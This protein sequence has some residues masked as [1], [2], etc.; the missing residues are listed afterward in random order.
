M[1]MRH[2]TVVAAAVGAMAAF[3]AGTGFANAQE[4]GDAIDDLTSAIDIAWLLIAGILVLFMQAGFGL[5]ESGFI[6]SK[7]VTNILMKNAL[8]LSFGAIAYWA[9]GWGLAYGTTEFIDIKFF[10]GGSFF[11]GGEDADYAG[12]FFQFAFAATAAT[13]VSGAVAE[14]TKFAA[15][16]VY[17]VVITAVIYPV[18]THWAWGDGFLSAY[19]SDIQ[20]GDNGMIDFAGSTVVHSVGGWAALVGAI[21]VGAR[22][23]KYNAGG[24]V[25]PLPGHSMPLGFLGVMIL[26]I[27]WYGFNA[28]STLG[29]SGGFADL[30]AR[31]AVTTTLAAGAGA[32][33]AMV[34]SR[35]RTGRSDLSLT[36]NGVL[37]GLVGITAG[38]AT[39][40]PW[41][42]VVIGIVAGAVIVFG[43]ELLDN[44]KID[45]PVGAVPVHLFN[46]IWGTLAVG[47]FTTQANL[48]PNYGDSSSYGLLVGGGIEQ[49]LIQALGV[50]AVGVWTVLTSVI[51]FTAIKYTVGL[52]VSEAEEESG[53]DVAEHAME[54]YPEFTG[55]RDPFGA[56]FGAAALSSSSGAPIAGGAPEA[57]EE[58]TRAES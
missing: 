57:D 23:G 34:I 45:D 25:N 13:I 28:G 17:T 24:S 26:W 38:C 16:L 11:Y 36:L 42:A 46:G 51:L 29:L 12:F 14:R 56:H 10:G 6:R 9:V 35:L 3:A 2:R 32:A 55:G 7:N 18:V 54:A 49:L 58:A 30:A 44:L 8:D 20:F 48:A 39:V 19:A 41:A 1:R 22:R 43:V 4:V 31:V 33:T 37:G 53:L 52:R 47:L 15:Y 50:I 21:M 27:G 40:E 5:V